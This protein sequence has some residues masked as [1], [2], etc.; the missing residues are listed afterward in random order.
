MNPFHKYLLECV[1]IFNLL[2]S[3]S[4]ISILSSIKRKTLL[5]ESFLLTKLN[6]IESL[7]YI[8]I[9]HTNF[10]NTV[11]YSK[12]NQVE[13][14]SLGRNKIKV[15]LVGGVF[16]LLHI[17]HIYT[18]K[19]AHSLGDILVV[20]IATNSTATKMKKNRKIY[21][22]ESSRLEL[23]SSLRFVD[24]ALIG[25]EGSLYESVEYVKPNI[26]AL[27]YDQNHDAA[28]I[29]KNCQIRGMELDVIR[30]SSPIPKIKS[31]I[32]KQELGS[33]FYDV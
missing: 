10:E 7:G 15:V 17:G 19:S 13:L 2:K 28:E 1:Y 24:I 30:M 14:T 33:F 18:L 20:I 31:S 12:D 21:H 5:D 8:K 9:N 22:N 26:I 29:K 25:K 16:D 23:V 3:D 32:I 27:G 6:E 4:S 11:K